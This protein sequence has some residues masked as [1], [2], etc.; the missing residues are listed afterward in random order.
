M[1][2]PNNKE[3]RKKL[4]LQAEMEKRKKDILTQKATRE[5]LQDMKK[6]AVEMHNDDPVTLNSLLK[7]IEAAESENM[8]YAKEKL[9]T[10]ESEMD[11]AVYNEPTEHAKKKYEISLK[12]RGVT[13]EEVHDKANFGEKGK[14][15]KVKV[16]KKTAKTNE[17]KEKKQ[18]KVKEI[19]VEKEEKPQNV[20]TDKC[21]IDTWEH[22][23]KD[24]LTT[25]GSYDDFDPNSIPANV[26]YDII[27]LPSN[28]ECY[29]SKKNRVPVAY[30]TAADENIMSSPNIIRDG[31]VI[32]LVLKRKILDKS[33]KVEDLCDGDIEAIVLWLRMTSFGPNLKLNTIDPNT[34]KEYETEV[35][36]RDLKYKEFNLK[37]DENGL[38]DYVTD[39][40]N[41][42][43][44]KF[45]NR[46]AVTNIL[47]RSKGTTVA[48]EKEN[49]EYCLRYIRNFLSLYGEADE[50]PEDELDTIGEA[51]SDVDS[52]G[53]NIVSTVLTDTV[54]EHT[55]SV[56][57]N[58]D[59]SYVKSFIE[60]MKI[61]E[62][63]AYRKYILDNEPGVDTT[64]TVDIPESD[65]GGSFESFLRI[66]DSFLFSD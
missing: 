56:N 40:G 10:T 12:N 63:K 36:L 53:K 1:I 26:Q 17:K 23:Y 62:F 46:F 60:N 32:E 15:T 51:I 48:I 57:G 6:T 31:K 47:E 4:E 58:T 11:N 43:K 28:G 16:G 37:G 39:S 5:L 2:D 9:K 21:G 66:R 61:G 14:T 18:K 30:L 7:D 27:P 20:E 8:Q 44:F 24:D 38:F 55:V 19:A 52:S 13:D 25:G 34:R 33:I 64:I 42:F 54:V 49:S 29:P 59:R 65:G 3:E 50:F 45:L 35:D 41:V 22:L